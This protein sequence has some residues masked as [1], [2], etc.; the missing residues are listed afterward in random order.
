MKWVQEVSPLT[1]QYFVSFTP[2]GMYGW[3]GRVLGQ[4]GPK[5]YYVQLYAWDECNSTTRRI[6]S[7]KDMVDWEFYNLLSELEANLDPE[8]IPQD[9]E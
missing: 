9:E 6:F 4:V 3:R 8:M 7:L 5:Y 2:R 1:D